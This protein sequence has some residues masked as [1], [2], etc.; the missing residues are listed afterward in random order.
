MSFMIEKT[1]GI[2]ARERT[3]GLTNQTQP[4]YGPLERHNSS[5]SPHQ[6]CTVKKTQICTRGAEILLV[7]VLQVRPLTLNS[8][9]N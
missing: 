4:L 6:K 9:T 7:S 2:S 1:E 5:A 8:Q 3:N